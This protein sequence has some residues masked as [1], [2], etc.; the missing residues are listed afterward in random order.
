MR[1]VVLGSPDSWYTRD[2]ARAGAGRH[3][4]TA[5]TFSDLSASSG[6]CGHCDESKTLVSNAT[7]FSTQQI[8]SGEVNLSQ[9]DCVLVRTMPP[10]SLEQVVFRMDGF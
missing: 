4:V 1:L 3:E 2:L 5:A 7:E 9:A 8:R 6:G 10:G